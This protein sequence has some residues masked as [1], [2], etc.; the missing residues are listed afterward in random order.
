[1]IAES[2]CT[3]CGKLYFKARKWQKYCSDLCRITAYYTRRASVDSM[4]AFLLEEGPTKVQEEE[5]KD[6][7]ELIRQDRTEAVIEKFKE[8]EKEKEKENKPSP[9][10]KYDPKK[11]NLS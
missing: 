9:L 11:E 7:T 4:D 10:D 6:R 5:W 2:T 1:M 3:Q 8:M